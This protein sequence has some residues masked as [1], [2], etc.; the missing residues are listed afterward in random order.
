MKLVLEIW[1][2]VLLSSLFPFSNEV[3][4]ELINNHL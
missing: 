1:I 3:F 4:I 2:A